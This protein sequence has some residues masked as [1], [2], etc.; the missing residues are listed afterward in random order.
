MG[1]EC[2]GAT[3]W[4][5][6]ALPPAPVRAVIGGPDYANLEIEPL[7]RAA[8]RDASSGHV[9]GTPRHRGLGLA[10]ALIDGDLRK[11]ALGGVETKDY[12]SHW[13]ELFSARLRGAGA[14]DVGVAEQRDWS[15]S[16]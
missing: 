2:C 3:A 11:A 15:W 5:I 10:R 7:R 16:A 1:V 14:R 8:G 13:P 9:L 12:P 4:L 6:A